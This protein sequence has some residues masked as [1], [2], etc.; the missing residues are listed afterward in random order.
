MNNSMCL[1]ICDGDGVPPRPAVR[2]LPPL[3]KERDLHRLLDH[4]QQVFVR[5]RTG[6]ADLETFLLDV[7]ADKPAKFLP[8]LGAVAQSLLLQ[9]VEPLEQVV[10]G[11]GSG[12]RVVLLS[13][14]RLSNEKELVSSFGRAAMMVSMASFISSVSMMAMP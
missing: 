8:L 14:V 12:R 11:G 5:G 9:A 2:V 7:G 10:K 3:R 1:F 4:V 6:H 13:F